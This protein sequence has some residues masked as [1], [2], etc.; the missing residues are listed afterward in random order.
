MLQIP[1]QGHRGKS[2]TAIL[3]PKELGCLQVLSHTGRP[4]GGDKA[5]I[6]KLLHHLAAVMHDQIDMLERQRKG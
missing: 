3:M 6:L 1:G 5:V 2:L 4:S